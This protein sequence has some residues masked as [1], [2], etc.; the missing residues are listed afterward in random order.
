[1]SQLFLIIS[2]ALEEALIIDEIFSDS[3]NFFEKE[4]RFSF[5][6]SLEGETSKGHFLKKKEKLSKNFDE[7]GKVILNEI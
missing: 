3:L 1:M 7:A 5:E 4:E 2:N 6:N